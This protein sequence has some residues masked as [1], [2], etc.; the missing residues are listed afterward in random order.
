MP[1]SCIAQR[2]HVYT[3]FLPLPCLGQYLVSTSLACHVYFML[4]SILFLRCFFFCLN[5]IFLFILYP[6]CII[7][8]VHIFIYFPPSSW[9][10]CLFVT[11]GGEYRHFYMTLVLFP[12]ERSSIYCTHSEGEKFLKGDAYTKGEK[13]SFYKKTM[14]C[15]VFHYVCF[16]V[17]FNGALSYV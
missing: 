1:W 10:I 17:F 5:F 6:S 2:H 4:Y 9:S 15:F 13:T 11:K 7:I 14:F 16:L 12:R 3:L 8:L